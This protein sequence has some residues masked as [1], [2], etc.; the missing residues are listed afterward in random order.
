MKQLYN[1]PAN[2]MCLFCVMPTIY[3]Y[4]YIGCYPGKNVEVL[5]CA[6]LHDFWESIAFERF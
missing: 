1:L 3:I 4:I 2:F 5:F 6:M